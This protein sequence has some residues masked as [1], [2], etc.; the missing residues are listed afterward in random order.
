MRYC[1]IASKVRDIGSTSID[2]LSVKRDLE[3]LLDRSIQTGEY[4]IPQHKRYGNN[5]YSYLH[6]G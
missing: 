5:Y 2:V 6:A 4:I 3:E 1:E